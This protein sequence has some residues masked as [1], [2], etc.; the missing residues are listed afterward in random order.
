MY[1]ELLIRDIPQYWDKIKFGC[2]QSDEIPP[3][4]EQ[5]YCEDLLNDLFSGKKHCA[6]LFTE[7]KKL[8]GFTLF[9]VNFD[10]LYKRKYLQILNV[11]SFIKQD[12]YSRSKTMKFYVTLCKKY[13]CEELRTYVRNEKVK[14]MC[15]SMGFQTYFYALSYFPED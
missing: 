3:E 6:L 10:S 15:E 7:D 9:I 4:L 12:D 5:S 14:Q 11:Y 2:L 1:L 8:I 13:S